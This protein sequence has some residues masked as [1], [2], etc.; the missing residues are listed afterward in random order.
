MPSVKLRDYVMSI[1][2]LSA[3]ESYALIHFAPQLKP[4][5]GLGRV[6]ERAV[7]L[8][9]GLLI[10]YQ[11]LIYPFFVS[12]LRKLPGPEGG[13]LIIGYGMIQFMK[14]PGEKLKQWMNTIPNDGLI[15]FRGFFNMPTIVPTSHEALKA[16]LSDHTYDY[17]KPQ[18]FINILR[19]ILGD[20]LI[21]VEGNIHKFQ[22]KRECSHFCYIALTQER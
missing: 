11:L 2:L 3:V 8:N 12:P 21:L 17:E 13:N 14:P 10:L 20:G 19:R 15:Y 18:R 9:I 5:G 16:V 4:T 7:L 22:R 1:V 6:L